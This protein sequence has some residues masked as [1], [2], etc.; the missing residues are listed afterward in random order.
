MPSHLN[1]SRSNR[2][3]GISAEPISLEEVRA[4]VFSKTEKNKKSTALIKSA[5][6]N[7]WNLMKELEFTQMNAIVQY[8]YPRSWNTGTLIIKQGEEGECMYV[9]EEGEVEVIRGGK[10]ISVLKCGQ[11][12]GELALIYNCT[13]TATIKAKTDCKLWVIKRDCFQTI[14]VNRRIVRKDEYSALLKEV[15]TFKDLPQNTLRAITEGL[16]EKKYRNGEYIVRQG[17]HGDYFFIIGEGQAK[18]TMNEANLEGE[19]FVRILNKGDFFGEKAL[20]GDEKRTANVIADNSE[21]E[22]VSC[23]AINRDEFCHIKDLDEIKNRYLDVPDRKQVKNEEFKSLNLDDLA[24]ITTLGVGAFGR[25]LLVKILGDKKE[26][27]FALKR[28][29]KKKILDTRQQKHVMSEK[30][31]ME[32]SDCSFIVKLFKTFE[33]KKFIYILTECFLGG[34]LWTLLRNNKGFSESTARFYVACVTEAFYYLHSKGII[35]RDLKPENILLDNKGYG[36]LVDLGFAKQLKDGEKTWTFCGTPEYV[37]PE[38]IQSHGH[39]I[40]ADYWALGILIYELLAARPPFT[41][42]D[43]LSTYKNVLQ[44]ISI[45]SAPRNCSSSGKDIIAKLCRRQPIL[46]LGY[47]KGGIRKI[48]KH[49]WFEGFNWEKLR[50]GSMDAPIT[51]KVQNYTDTSNFDEFPDDNDV[52]EGEATEDT[53]TAWNEDF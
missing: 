4:K 41:G 40:S 11:I 50:L 39:D 42:K 25:V 15:A 38:I 29:S 16:I 5:I 10:S 45:T 34:E 14:M 6:M 9:I 51:P 17:D 43:Q 36:K 3:L 18:V 20:I 19:K 49:E 35:Y 2:G 52:A 8:M 26:R 21:G 48:Q 32:E 28:M 22:W 24:I 37:A 30:Q 33:N 1:I 44:G 27:S 23:F 31:I 7:S 53:F 46:R 13:R 12:F 47:Q